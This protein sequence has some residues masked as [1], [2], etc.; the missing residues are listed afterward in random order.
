MQGPRGSP[1]APP[2][3]QRPCLSATAAPSAGKSGVVSRRAVWERRHSGLW[4]VERRTRVGHG[5]EGSLR[6]DPLR[7]ATYYERREKD[8]ERMLSSLQTAL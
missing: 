6:S 5:P 2:L 8:V 1:L 4:S 7:A 3:Q